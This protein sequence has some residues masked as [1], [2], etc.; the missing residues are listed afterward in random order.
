MPISDLYGSGEHIR[1][2]SHFSSLVYLASAGDG[3]KPQEEEVL[4][5]LAI[6]LGISEEEYQEA[7]K[8]PS[9]FPVSTSNAYERRIERLYDILTVVFADGTM[10]AEE[11]NLLRKYALA[12]GFSSKDAQPLIDKSIRI[13]SGKLSFEEYTSLLNK[14]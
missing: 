9:N 14:E 2:F 11:E 3:I 12:I 8:N 5:R 4:N 7:L 1:N 10:T 13:L 6:K